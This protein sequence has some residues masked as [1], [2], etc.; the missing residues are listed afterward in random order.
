MIAGAQT[1]AFLARAIAA[2]AV[3]GGRWL[4][5]F[6]AK[7]SSPNLVGAALP[8]FAIGCVSLA[9]ARLR[10]VRSSQQNLAAI[11]AET[12]SVVAALVAIALA[13][14]ECVPTIRPKCAALGQCVRG[15]IALV[16]CAPVTWSL[17]YWRCAIVRARACAGLGF[18]CVV[19]GCV[20]IV[21]A[22][23]SL[24]AALG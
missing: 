3:A 1:T 18:V 15:A 6:F 22:G 14:G 8:R 2:N 17:R 4:V 19:A 13:A 11:A 21:L 10:A 5:G 16:G 23:C 9:V 12:A 20:A 7:P 24:A